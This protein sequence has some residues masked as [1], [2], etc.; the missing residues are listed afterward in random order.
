M[1]SCKRATELISKSMEQSLTVKEQ[2]T[3]KLHLF[4]CEFCEQ[5]KTQLGTF[6]KALRCEEKGSVLDSIEDTTSSKEL[7]S[8]CK[9]KIKQ[10]IEKQLRQ[11]TK[12]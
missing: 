9:A 6:R 3:L 8:D 11:E 10:E 7:S 1:I 2:L 5:F 12:D 4:I